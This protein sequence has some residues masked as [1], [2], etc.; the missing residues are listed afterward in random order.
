MRFEI[1]R[2]TEQGE[3]FAHTYD[4]E[5]LLLEEDG[6]RLSAPAEVGGRVSRK[7]Q[8]VRLRGR[9]RAQVEAR[10]DRCLKPALFPVEANFDE[11]YVPAGEEVKSDETELHPDELSFS[12]YAGETLDADELV[13]EQILLALPA[14][15]LCR[16][17]CKGL[18]PGCGADL[19]SEP[20]TCTRD[21]VDPRWAALAAMKKP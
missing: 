19:N 1:D 10:C 6:A 14:R 17:E 8:E 9:V 13:R 21:E 3:P 7:G 20:C 15:L 12:V 11:R 5:E 18:C 4:L 2:L 16:E